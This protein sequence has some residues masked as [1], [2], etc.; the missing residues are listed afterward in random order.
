MLSLSLTPNG[1][2]VSVW[3]E[4]CESSRHAKCFLNNIISRCF[5]RRRQRA[6]V[7][8]ISLREIHRRSFN[9]SVGRGL[10]CGRRHDSASR[11]SRFSSG[12]VVKGSNHLHCQHLVLLHEMA[13]QKYMKDLQNNPFCKSFPICS[14]R[15]YI[16]HVTK[17]CQY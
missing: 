17:R 2:C 4:P 13:A 10:Q 5:R 3:G 16:A 6:A 8:F 12:I 15:V 9:A 1:Q 7:C 14:A 11:T